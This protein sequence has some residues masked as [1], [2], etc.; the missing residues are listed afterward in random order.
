MT[1]TY[2][3]PF[4]GFFLS[5]ALRGATLSKSSMLLALLMLVVGRLGGALALLVLETD[6]AIAGGARPRLSVDACLD[7]SGVPA[8][9]LGGM[10][11]GGALLLVTKGGGGVPVGG[12]G[13]PE[14]E[15]GPA[16]GGGGVAVLAGVFSAP[17]FLLTHRFSSG[18][19]TKLLASPSFARMGLPGEESPDEVC[20]RG[21]FLLPPNQPPKPQPFLDDCWA[22]A[23]L[24]VTLVSHVSYRWER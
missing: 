17:G 9:T 8:R 7:S 6:R 11:G 23:R 3:P 24:A 20:S 19:Y 1:S 21:A 18:S 16:L 22:A 12:G 13:V 15:R 14:T 10:R 2:R 5:L 4:R